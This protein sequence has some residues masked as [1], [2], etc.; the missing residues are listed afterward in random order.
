[1]VFDGLEK[2]SPQRIVFIMLRAV[3]VHQKEF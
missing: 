3:K 2:N 1:M